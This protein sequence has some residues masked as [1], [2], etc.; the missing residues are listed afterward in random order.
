M[1]RV[2]RVLY[3][4]SGREII[5][6]DFFIT[7]Q[8]F[9][10]R[11]DLER[12]LWPPARAWTRKKTS[13]KGREWRRAIVRAF[14]LIQ[15]SRGKR[16]A[17]SRPR[18]RSALS[19]SSSGLKKSRLTLSSRTQIS[20]LRNTKERRDGHEFRLISFSLPARSVDVAI[21]HFYSLSRR[22]SPFFSTS[23]E[24]SSSTVKKKQNIPLQE[25]DFLNAALHISLRDCCPKLF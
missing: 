11:N 4:R 24:Q 21:S 12:T 16:I 1:G 22:V 14:W 2:R 9:I 15:W 3:P 18:K 7:I 6:V 23:G 10:N 20:I 17:S 19:H 13:R 25:I 5:R 8:H